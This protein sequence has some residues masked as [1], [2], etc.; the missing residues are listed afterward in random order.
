MWDSWAARTVLLRRLLPCVRFLA[1][2]VRRRTQRRLTAALPTFLAVGI[3]LGLLARVAVRRSARR[4][5]IRCPTPLGPRLQPLTTRRVARHL[6]RMPLPLVSFPGC[7]PPAA[8]RGRPRSAHAR[9][10][11]RAVLLLAPSSNRGAHGGRLGTAEHGQGKGL[12]CPARVEGPGRR[13]E[14]PR[15]IL[16]KPRELTKRA[17]FRKLTAGVS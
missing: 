5:A 12:E 10:T 4:G 14:P 2:S 7:P 1:F 8:A 6:P 15:S 11:S 13:G 17:R 9:D 3:H 16:W